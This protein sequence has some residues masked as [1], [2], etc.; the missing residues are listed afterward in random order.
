MAMAALRRESQS[1]GQCR[2]RNC[3]MSLQPSWGMRGLE[4]VQHRRQPPSKAKKPGSLE[5]EMVELFVGA[6]GKASDRKGI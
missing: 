4:A 6:G 2:A 1:G 3:L 5:Y